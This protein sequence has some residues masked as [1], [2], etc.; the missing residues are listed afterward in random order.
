MRMALG[1]LAIIGIAWAADITLANGKYSMAARKM[2]G[3]IARH[4]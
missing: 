4:F 2:F 3:E 1:V